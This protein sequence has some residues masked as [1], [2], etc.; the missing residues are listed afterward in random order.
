M[1]NSLEIINQLSYVIC[2]S[3]NIFFTRPFHICVMNFWG[4]TDVGPIKMN[5]IFMMEFNSLGMKMQEGGAQS[6]P[7]SPVGLPRVI[8][9]PSQ[10]AREISCLK[11]SLSKGME[12]MI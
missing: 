11:E 1:S 7:S 3:E 8:F 9:L 5:I 2:K 6:T 4:E 12:S 10:I